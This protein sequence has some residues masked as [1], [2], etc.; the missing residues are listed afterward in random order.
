VVG[1]LA[2]SACSGG[3]GSSSSAAASSS[4][5]GVDGP[6]TPADAAALTWDAP[7]AA[8]FNGTLPAA[9]PT[10]VCGADDR[11][12]LGE[13][14]QGN[15]L[16]Y[17]VPKR[18]AEV[19]PVPSQVVISGTAE[20]PS[21]GE[22]DFP[23]D[24]TMGSDFNMNVKLDAP[25]MGVGQEDGKPVD[26]VH[27]ELAEGQFPHLPAAA[28]PATMDWTKMSAE[29][30]EGF[31]DGFLPRAGDRVLVM[32]TWIVDCGHIGFQTE[33]HPITFMAVARTEGDATVVH[34][35]YNPYRETQLYNADP[36]KTTNFSTPGR[37]DD[38]SNVPF[39]KALVDSIVRVA[40]GEPATNSD[41][42]GL[43]SWAVMAPNTTSPVAW[44]VCPPGTPG[45]SVKVG[46]ALVARDGAQVDVT[47]AGG[48][49]EVTVDL[50]AMTP[51]VPEMHTC[52][53]TWEFLSEVAGEEAAGEERE[54]ET[55][56][57]LRKEISK[58]VPESIAAKLEPDPVMNCYSPLSA[59]DL[60]GARPT[61]VSVASDPGAEMPFFGTVVVRAGS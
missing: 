61:K 14:L 42:K 59:K 22:G 38:P 20:E 9:D 31:Q 49:A 57:D 7:A 28:Q 56:I 48:C 46:A 23:F 53:T 19:K 51:A 11:R 13:L 43:A 35:F 27:V 21:L 44:T 30:R 32:G 36:A 5:S 24:H 3:D 25:F 17:K 2:L 60:G 34:T 1:A 33:L 45:S 54:G 37:L 47:P 15:P 26:S 58:F 52:V 10:T 55:A 8:A 40:K 50:S 12:F 4:T 6:A 41:A 29:S 18:L 16:E 39:P